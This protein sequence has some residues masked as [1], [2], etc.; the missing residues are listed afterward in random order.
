MIVDLTKFLILWAIVI[1]MFSSITVISFASIDEF[2]T[3]LGT[4]VY[5]MNASFG[6]YNLND[7][8]IEPIDDTPEQIEIAD[9]LSQ[10]GVYYM[11]A[12]LLL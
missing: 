3:Y 10:M 1:L 8:K 4:T 11:L 6:K 12:Y 2:R 7:F 9:N 5:L